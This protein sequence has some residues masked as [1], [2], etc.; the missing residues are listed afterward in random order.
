MRSD[1]DGSQRGGPL[2]RGNL[3]KRRA[4]MATK[5]SAKKA[6]TSGKAADVLPGMPGKFVVMGMSGKQNEA[7]A[8][9]MR[10]MLGGG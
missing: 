3:E 10:K 4:T 2:E 9:A 1:R 7:I 6:T 8:A 5:K